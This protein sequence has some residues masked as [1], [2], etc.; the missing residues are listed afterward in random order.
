M[1][2]LREHCLPPS[3]LHWLPLL[4]S[5]L[6]IE[7]YLRLLS[8]PTAHLIMKGIF[9]FFVNVIYYQVRKQKYL[10]DIDDGCAVI[11]GLSVVEQQR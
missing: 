7:S 3:M 6:N 1:L 11:F 5:T 10:Q 9:I 4:Y 8:L 2:S